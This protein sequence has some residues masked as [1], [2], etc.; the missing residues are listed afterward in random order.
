MNKTSR[1]SNQTA[2]RWWLF[3]ATV[4]GLM[5]CQLAAAQTPAGQDAARWKSVDQHALAAPTDIEKDPATLARW[6]TEPFTTPQEKLRA[7]YRWIAEHIEYDVQAYH[8]DR[9]SA[10]DPKLVLS[11]RISA[12]EGYSNLFSELALHAGIK[13]V[14]KIDGFVKDARHQNG[15]AFTK[16]NHAWNA[17]LIDGEWRLIDSTWGAGYDAGDKYVKRF[18]PMYFLANPEN[19]RHSHFAQIPAQRFHA[20]TASVDAFREQPYIAN[21]LL[22]VV[23]PQLL[24]PTPSVLPKTFDHAP[25]TFWVD[26]A[27]MS[28]VLTAGVP[29]QFRLLSDT[30]TEFALLNNDKWTLEPVGP[31]GSKLTIV[32]AVGSLVLLG[33]TAGSANYKYLLQYEVRSKTTP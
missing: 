16:S 2:L 6:L 30:L 8:E 5:W 20:R 9:S 25:G 4:A 7:I 15:E 13:Y 19:L 28:G 31:E 22:S 18:E 1:L 12:C 21:T 24:D 29:V 17:F 26:R 3:L 11:K 33:N 23:N 32:P 10:E 14:Q 27:P